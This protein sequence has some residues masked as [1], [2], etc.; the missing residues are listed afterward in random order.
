MNAI[1]VS[2]RH[3]AQRLA[4]AA[5]ALLLV[6]VLVTIADIAVRPIGGIYVPGIVDLMQLMVMWSAPLAIPAAFLADEHVAVDLFTRAMPAPV[7][8]FLRMMGALMGVAVL[9][10]LAWFGAEQGWREHTSGDR[11]QTLG[12][13]LGIYWLPL[14]AGMGLS[15]LACLALAAQA[16]VQLVTGRNGEAPSAPGPSL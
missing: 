12:L 9:A 2:L 14:L 1:V 13:P 10:L 3:W 4:N 15:A 5:Q 16:A 7:Q 6:G 11:T 8:R